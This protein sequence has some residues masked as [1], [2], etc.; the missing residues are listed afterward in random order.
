VTHL[1]L[2]DA[3]RSTAGVARLGI[4]RFEALAAVRTS[5]AHY[6]PLAAK[7]SVAFE[8]FEMA[9]VP[10]LTLGFGALVGEDYLKCQQ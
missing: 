6:V 10:T 9:H 3:D 2:V 4:E 5:G 8:A 1:T 7:M